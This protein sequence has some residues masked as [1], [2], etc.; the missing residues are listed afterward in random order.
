MRRS[1]HAMDPATGRE[2]VQT[3]HRYER[4]PVLRK[5][6]ED[7]GAELFAGELQMRVPFRIVLPMPI[8]FPQPRGSRTPPAASSLMLTNKAVSC[9]LALV[10]ITG[11][12]AEVAAQDRVSLIC[13]P[14]DPVP[15][16]VLDIDFAK[17]TVRRRPNTEAHPASFTST[18]IRYRDINFTWEIDR[19]TGDM[20]FAGRPGTVQANCQPS[21][22]ARF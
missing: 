2:L 21:G 20:Y 11:G 12:A 16:Y 7:A 3:M 4:A 14:F 17:R 6:P 5:L 8:S 22:G 19:T 15:R 10:C 1:V 18:T 13:Q 9:I